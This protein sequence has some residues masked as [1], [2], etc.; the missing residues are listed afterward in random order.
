[1]HTL[2]LWY[3]DGHGTSLIKSIK[4][5][6]EKLLPENHNVRIVLKSTRLTSQFN[7]K[8]DTNKQQKNGLVYFSWCTSTTSTGS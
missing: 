3:E 4:I 6:T 1:M 7:I 8:D 2:K 5:S